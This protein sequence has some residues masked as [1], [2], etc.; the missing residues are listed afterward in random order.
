MLT[1]KRKAYLRARYAANRETIRA[2]HT[3]WREANREHLREYVNRKRR[4]NPDGR[5]LER[6]RNGEQIRAKKR[7]DYLKDGGAA[8]K[9]R[10]KLWKQKNPE[11]TKELARLWKKKNPERHRE[12]K[13]RAWLKRKSTLRGRINHNMGRLLWMALHHKGGKRGKSWQELLGFTP[14]QLRLHLEARFLPGMTWDAYL[15]GEIH[16]D[17]IKPIS[18]FNYDSTEHPDFK[19]CWS[20][21]NLQPMWAKDNVTKQARWAG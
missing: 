10:A 2:K 1:E 13:R 7:A 6:E 16:T 20:L 17:H 9:L 3:A 5:R 12:N 19:A 8:A 4:E 11:R 21:D 18:W 15:R 14:D